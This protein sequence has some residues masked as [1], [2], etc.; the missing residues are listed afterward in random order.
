[1][2]F[3]I[4]PVPAVAAEHDRHLRDALVFLVSAVLVTPLFRRL[5]FSAILGYLVAGATIG[6]SGLGL[7]AD[8]EGTRALAELGVVFLLF[9][10]GLELSLERLKAMRRYVLGLGT[11]QV[12]VTAALLAVAVRLLLGPSPAAAA[13]VGGALALSSTAFVSQLLSER[14]EMATRHG[15]A[16]LGTLL[17]QD[18]AVVPFLVVL[19]L[20]DRPPEALLAALGVVGARAALAVVAIVVVGRLLLRPVYHLI[21]GTR[22]PELFTAATLLLVL[23]TGWATTQAGL[24]MAMGAF[25]VGLLVSES[26]FRHQ[27]EAEIQPFKGILLGLFFM[28][29]GMVIDVRLAIAEPALV[30]GLVAGLMAVKS[31]VLLGLS[32]LAGLPWAGAARVAV[33]LCQGGEFAFVLLSLALLHGTVP[34]ATVQLLFL[35]VGLS[36]ALTPLLVIGVSA[37]AA[38]AEGRSRTTLGTIAAE[39]AELEGHVIV[40][41]YGRFGRVATRLLGD[42]M[43]DMVVLDLTP[44]VVAE[45]RRHGLPVFYADCTRPEVLRLVGAERARAAVLTVDDPGVTARTVAVMRRHFP[46]LR[47]VARAHDVAHGQALEAEGAHVTVPESLEASLQLGAEA[48]REAGVDGAEIGHLVERLRHDLAV[49][50]APSARE[51]PGDAI[52]AL[53]GDTAEEPAADAVAGGPK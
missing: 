28:T 6:P 38:R 49:G 33:L 41:G 11:A 9:V 51:R 31:L 23:G 15:R 29:V 25:L 8:V 1:M 17:M 12:V 20:L 30:A 48:L 21:A 42:E 5:R 24:S 43:V 45:G 53:S 39:T 36:M 3:L 46:R 19:P 22:S 26:E 47:I 52:V 35:V 32:R 7:I 44:R 50:A 40:C 27:V 4:D 13:V 10:I 14:G 37:L 34:Y 2:E 18:L 16:A